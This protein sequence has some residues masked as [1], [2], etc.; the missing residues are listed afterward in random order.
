M[1]SH[2]NIIHL[3]SLSKCSRMILG[4]MHSDHKCKYPVHIPMYCNQTHDDMGMRLSE[5]KHI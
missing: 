1:G 4:M 2:F 5:C 3:F